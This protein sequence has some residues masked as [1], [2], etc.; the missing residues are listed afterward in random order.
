M[1]H[2]NSK[3]LCCCVKPRTH[4]YCLR[5]HKFLQYWKN[6]KLHWILAYAKLSE[7]KSG[8]YCEIFTV[9]CVDSAKCIMI[10][11]CWSVIIVRF[12]YIFTKFSAYYYEN[13]FIVGKCLNMAWSI[14][15][16]AETIQCHVL[17]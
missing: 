17:Y 2:Y 14:G 12:R 13:K 10:R 4:L 8:E 9:Q 1:L 7:E 5:E 3:L 15:H 6:H 16:M 11:S